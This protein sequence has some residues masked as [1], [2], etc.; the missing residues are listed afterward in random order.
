MFLLLLGDTF[1]TFSTTYL[2][3]Q[4]GTLL[5][6][7]MSPLASYKLLMELPHILLSMPSSVLKKSEKIL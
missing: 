2:F 3:S 5:C 6:S 1:F 7:S 4:F